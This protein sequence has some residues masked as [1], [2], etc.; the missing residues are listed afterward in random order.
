MALVVLMLNSFSITLALPSEPAFFMHSSIDPEL[1]LLREYNSGAKD[2]SQ[3][4][5]KSA[6][7]SENEASIS[8][9]HPR[10]RNNRQ[11]SNRNVEQPNVTENEN[12]PDLL[13]LL[14]AQQ[15]QLT[16]LLAN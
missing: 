10:Y 5:N 15:A 11:T 4:T 1:P 8:E 6:H 12:P 14:A 3:L 7:F 9:L 13:T 2:S 16:P